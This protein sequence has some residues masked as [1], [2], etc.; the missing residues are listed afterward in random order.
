MTCSGNEGCTKIVEDYNLLRIA[1]KTTCANSVEYNFLLFSLSVFNPIGR[2]LTNYCH[3]FSSGH[4][5]KVTLSHICGE[6]GTVYRSNAT[7]DF[8]ADEYTTKTQNK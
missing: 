5:L 4:Q 7:L 8:I 6:L 3:Y 1:H 2:A